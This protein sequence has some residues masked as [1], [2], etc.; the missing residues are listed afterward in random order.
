[1][2]QT[3]ISFVH[4]KVLAWHLPFLESRISIMHILFL[5][6]DEHSHISYP[7]RAITPSALRQCP[8]RAQQ[9]V[10]SFCSRNAATLLANHKNGTRKTDTPSRSILGPLAASPPML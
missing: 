3:K 7:R 10:A 6:A 1:M 5:C 4:L 9:N 2:R 8:S